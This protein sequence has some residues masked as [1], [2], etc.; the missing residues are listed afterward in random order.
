MISFSL[1]SLDRTLF[2]LCLRGLCV[3]E[4]ASRLL[5][6][7]DSVCKLTLASVANVWHCRGA[8]ERGTV[9]LFS[10]VYPGAGVR[11]P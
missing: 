2:L 7:A 9:R 10:I 3:V 8:E 11:A 1:V 6:L 5:T 4:G